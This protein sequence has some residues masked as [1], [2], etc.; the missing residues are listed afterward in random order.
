[1]PHLGY[2]CRGSYPGN[3]SS[4]RLVSDGEWHSVF[5][6]VKNTSV[7]LLIDGLGNASLQLPGTCGISRGRRDLLFGGLRQP[8]QSQRVSRGFRGCLDVLAINGRE[9]VLLPGKGQS[10]EV[11]E[12]VGIKQC[13][14]PT[15]ACSSNPC[16]NNGMCS[17]THGGGTWISYAEQRGSSEGRESH[18]FFIC[19][20]Q[21][22]S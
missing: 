7:R 22:A 21:G 11:V 2:S 16:L 3:L 9:V 4:S 17:E 6:E 20:Y 10:K 15:G 19:P 5:L 1:M 8:L 18:N 12:E 13:C 14:S